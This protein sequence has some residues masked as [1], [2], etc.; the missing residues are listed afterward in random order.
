MKHIFRSLWYLSLLGGFV[1]SALAADQTWTDQIS[2]SLC[3]AS[4][5]QMIS[6]KYKALRTSSGAPQHD[7]ALACV[8]DGGRFVFV[9]NEKVYKIANQNLA[10]V[11]ENAGNT[12]ELTGGMQGDT[13]TVSKIAPSTQK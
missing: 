13:I 5:D 11:Q 8:K 7:C 9:I 4:H 6:L 10:A 1:F 3:G 12:V 2:D